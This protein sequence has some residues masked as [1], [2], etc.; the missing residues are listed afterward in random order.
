MMKDG[1]S[2]SIVCVTRDIGPK[3][4]SDAVGTT[5]EDVLLHTWTSNINFLESRSD[6]TMQTTLRSDK[7]NVRL[8]LPCLD[9][10][11]IH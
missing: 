7:T 1:P 2:T 3:P 11:L 9:A 4:I 6:I 5:V 8:A 10:G